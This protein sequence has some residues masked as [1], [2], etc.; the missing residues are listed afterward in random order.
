VSERTSEKSEA[1]R[2]AEIEQRFTQAQMDE[3]ALIFKLLDKD[4]CVVGVW[5]DSV[6]QCLCANFPFCMHTS[7]S[8][9]LSHTHTP[10]LFVY[11]C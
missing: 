2:Q 8:L 1:S 4:G 3:M 10:S 6:L 7:F 5:F 9:S 11:L